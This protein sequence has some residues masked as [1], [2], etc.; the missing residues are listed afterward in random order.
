VNETG[1]FSSILRLDEPPEDAGVAFLLTV[2]EG[3]DEDDTLL[4][5]PSLP[6]RVFIG[7]SSSCEL[8]LTDDEVARRHVGLEVVGEK[9]RVSDLAT[10]SGTMA[11]GIVVADAFMRGGEVLRIG[12]SAIR[13]ERR[14]ATPFSKSSR[15]E[16]FGRVVGAS[17]EMQRLYPLCSRLAMSSVPVILE[18]EPGTGKEVLAE[19]LHEQGP[20][21]DR[22]FVVFD[23]TAVPPAL[24][25]AELFDAGTGAFDRAQGGTLLIDEVTELELPLQEK[26]LRTL[27]RTDLDVRVI[28]ATRRDLDRLVEAGRFREDLFERMSL[29]ARVELPPL[30]RRTGDVRRLA[31][32]FAREI[33]GPAA[34]LPPDRV[35]QWE[36]DPWPGNVRELREVVARW[37]ALGDLAVEMTSRGEVPSAPPTAP[38]GVSTDPF[39]ED[40][41]AQGLPLVQAR[42]RVIAELERRFAE[43]V[44]AEHGGSV[45][46]AVE[47]SGIARRHFQRL[48]TRR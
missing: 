32:H 3:P 41:L 35:A 4:V 8:R 9:L 36:G 14:H 2:V 20:R 38:G 27:E 39:L 23:C 25:G 48:E 21:A 18:G 45:A 6:T 12:R 1:E 42:E 5:D 13:V 22:P 29:A 24:V 31:L 30:R 16:R 37:L 46:S 11:D 43:R 10:A 33:G 44:I 28:H 19:A 40:V 7:T 34:T 47:A 15:A 17:A 26:L